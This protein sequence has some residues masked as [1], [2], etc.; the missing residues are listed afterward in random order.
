[1]DAEQG[2]HRASIEVSW[3]RQSVLSVAPNECAGGVDERV[4]VVVLVASVV[5]DDGIVR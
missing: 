5:D 3:D 4:H 1:M 2:S